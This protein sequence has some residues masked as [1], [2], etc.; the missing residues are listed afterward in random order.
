M[1]SVLFPVIILAIFL[2]SCNKPEFEKITESIPLDQRAANAFDFCINNDY[3]KDYCIL[4]DMSIHSGKKRLHLWDF[5]EN[6]V[7]ESYLVSHGCCKNQW[8]EDETR[9]SPRFSNIED[10]HC[11]SLGK[12][13]VGKRGWSSFGVNINYRL[14]GLE[15]SNSNAFERNIVFHSWDK[16]GDEETYPAGT[17]EGWGCPAVSDKA[18]LEIDPYLKKATKPT[19]LWIY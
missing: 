14:H 10:S 8:S 5:N 17:P 2:A 9:N 3:N 12:Y 4:V 18:F 6:K 16:I 13:R 15:P 19:L 1:K 7:I 11:S